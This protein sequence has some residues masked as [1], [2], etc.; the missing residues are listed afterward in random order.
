MNHL[1]KIVAICLP[2]YLAAGPVLSQTATDTEN[3]EETPSQPKIRV[4]PP[5]YDAQMMRLSE[6]LGSLHYLR[7]LCGANEGQ[8]WREQMQNLI[9]KEEPTPERK[10]RMTA[11]FNQGF[12][13]FQET[14]RS[15]TAAALEANNRYIAEGEKLANEI[16]SRY[17]R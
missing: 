14:Y 17:G 13:G 15:C 2:V 4:L 9:V 16:P 8:L 10:A 3:S 12:R 11:R 6:I 5:A 1:A 7:E